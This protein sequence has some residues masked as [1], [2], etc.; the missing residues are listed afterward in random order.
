MEILLFCLSTWFGKNLG[1]VERGHIFCTNLPKYSSCHTLNFFKGYSSFI[2]GLIRMLRGKF[3]GQFSSVLQA[4]EEFSLDLAGY[5][6]V[7]RSANEELGDL[8]VGWIMSL[9]HVWI[10]LMCG[11]ML[12]WGVL[13]YGVTENQRKN[14]LLRN[15]ID[16]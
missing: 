12:L 6:N 2:Y 3:C 13:I 14:L 15:L 10:S 5:F 8:T 1:Y 9:I 4:S 16:L 7:I 11:I